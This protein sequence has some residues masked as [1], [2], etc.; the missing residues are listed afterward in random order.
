MVLSAENCTL[1][2]GR[3]GWASVRGQAV[4]LLLQLGRNLH[5][6]RSDLARHLLLVAHHLCYRRSKPL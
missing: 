2:L 6:A 4:S 5:E 1:S 3:V